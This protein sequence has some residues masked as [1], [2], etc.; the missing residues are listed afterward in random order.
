MVVAE[1][2]PKTA[3]LWDVDPK[4][5]VEPW[6]M[7]TADIDV[8]ARVM[9][10]VLGKP[11]P[12]GAARVVVEVLGNVVATWDVEPSVAVD[13]RLKAPTR[14]NVTLRVVVVRSGKPSARLAVVPSKVTVDALGRPNPN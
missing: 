8:E 2:L 3:A 1:A 6:L 4:V 7:P 12:A 11:K 5:A 10:S 14:P 9:V 13:V